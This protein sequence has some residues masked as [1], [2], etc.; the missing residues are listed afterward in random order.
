MGSR[1]VITPVTDDAID[2][3]TTDTGPVRSFSNCHAG[4]SPVSTSISAHRGLQPLRLAS[5]SHGTMFSSSSV[6]ETTTSPTD[7]WEASSDSV[8]ADISENREL[9]RTTPAGSPPTRS[10]MARRARSVT[11]AEARPDG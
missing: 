10:A 11:S 4:S 8:S 6:R 1:S 7:L 3:V 9:P 5:R 2:T